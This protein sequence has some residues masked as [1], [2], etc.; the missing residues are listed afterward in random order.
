MSARRIRNKARLIAKTAE[1]AVAVPP[2]VA[3]RITRMAIAG[4]AISER[5]RREFQRMSAEK[6]SAFAES[7]TAMAAQAIRANQAFAVSL[8]RSFWFPL[9]GGHRASANAMTSQWQNAA[10]DVLRHGMAPVHRRAVANASR[11]A[12]TKL[13]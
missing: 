6:T 9:L 1:L 4:P 12:R 13:R 5:D 11:L 2:V 10:Y 7:W 8:V 3:H